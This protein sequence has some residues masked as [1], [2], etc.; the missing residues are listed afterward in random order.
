MNGHR[1]SALGLLLLVIG[2]L[3]ARANLVSDPGFESCTSFGQTLPPGWS[4]T[5]TCDNTTGVAPHSGN[6]AA[7]V[8]SGVPVGESTQTLSQTITLR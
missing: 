2:I 6:W 7:L 3:P 1:A 8:G 4:G 5:A